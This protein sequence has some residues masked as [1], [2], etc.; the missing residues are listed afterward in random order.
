MQ[1]RI[2]D[3]ANGAMTPGPRTCE[4]LQGYGKTF[5]PQWFFRPPDRA[6]EGDIPPRKDWLQGPVLP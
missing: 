3:G 4:G 5:S 1:G 6:P 2:I